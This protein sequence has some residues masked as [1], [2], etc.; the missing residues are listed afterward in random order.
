MSIEI[1]ELTLSHVD[2]NCLTEA[3][4]MTLFGNAVSHRMV[5]GRT[6]NVH[7]ITDRDGRTLYPGYFYTH[8]KV[9]TTRL[10]SEHRL[11][12]TVAVGV[13]VASFGG[14]VVDSTYILGQPGDFGPDAE[15]WDLPKFPSMRAGALFVVEGREGDPQ[16]AIPKS[17]MVASM[18]KLAKPPDAL[19]RFAQVE[20]KSLMEPNPGALRG[21]PIEY[22]LLTGRDIAPGH[23][24]MF[25]TFTR[26]MDAGERL[27]LTERVWPAFPAALCNS[28]SILERELFYL[29]NCRE[30]DVMLIDLVATLRACP[31]T[32]LAPRS[33]VVSAALLEETVDMYS[34]RSGH[35][36]A[37]AKVLKVFAV[38]S[39]EKA[40]QREAS[41]LVAQHAV[42]ATKQ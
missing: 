33:D 26:L 20:A 9:P 4:L 28:L 42:V 22:P 39:A 30:N 1:V 2:L 32:M 34:R 21:P 6:N 7:Q 5:E 35:R 3:A 25:A 41:R 12:S 15:Q 19:G 40:L 38:P 29:G 31:P 18:P 14:M 27:L 16:P 24:L 8:L 23:A 13:D 10:L 11:W 36:I 37:A 17:D